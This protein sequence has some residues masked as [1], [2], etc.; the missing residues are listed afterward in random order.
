MNRAAPWSKNPRVRKYQRAAGSRRVCAFCVRPLKRKRGATGSP[1]GRVPMVC[2]SADCRAELERENGKHHRALSRAVRG[3]GA[4][5]ARLAALL[6]LVLLF[7]RCGPPEA[8]ARVSQHVPSF[9]CYPEEKS[10]TCAQGIYLA[11]E[12]VPAGPLEQPT[13]RWVWRDRGA[14]P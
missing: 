7:A 5:V 14:C 8:C 1:A 3:V 2:W 13:G 6:V 9:V 11:C 12:E 10:P 4:S